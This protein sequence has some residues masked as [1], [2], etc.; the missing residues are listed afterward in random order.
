MDPDLTPVAM[1]PPAATPAPTTVV[2]VPN[3]P[4]AA[5]NAVP[6]NLVPGVLPA[7]GTAVFGLRPVDKADGISRRQ[8]LS[9][10]QQR[11]A[12]WKNVSCETFNAEQMAR[13][14]N[15]TPVCTCVVSY[16]LVAL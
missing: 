8:A 11:I 6:Q 1:P 10:G 15:S 14:T 16:G 7:P 9:S 13:F 2:M 4:Q 5:N 3:P 12:A